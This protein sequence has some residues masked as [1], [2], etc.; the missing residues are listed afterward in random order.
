MGTG[1]VL[2]DGVRGEFDVFRA[3]KADHFQE[4]GF[5]QCDNI[6]A[7]WAGNSLAKIYQGEPNMDATSGTRHFSGLGGLARMVFQ[8]EQVHGGNATAQQEPEQDA[9]HDQPRRSA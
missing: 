7:V 1:D 5:A 2:A 6:P 3:V 9:R 8:P 4:F